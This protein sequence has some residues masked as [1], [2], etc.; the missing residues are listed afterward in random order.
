[1]M[2]PP[3]PIMAFHHGPFIVGSTNKILAPD[4]SRHGRDV[5]FQSFLGKRSDS[6]LPNHKVC[7]NCKREAIV[8]LTKIASGLL[9]ATS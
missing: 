7:Y 4:I 2:N 8:S 3:D 9:K 6:F 1:M 5:T